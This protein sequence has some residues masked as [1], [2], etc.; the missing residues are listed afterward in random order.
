MKRRFDEE[1]E[2]IKY[3]EKNC[4]RDTKY[5]DLMKEER[6]GEIRENW[7]KERPRKE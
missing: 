6:C 4:M 5:N 7:Q 3:G 1:G 2:T